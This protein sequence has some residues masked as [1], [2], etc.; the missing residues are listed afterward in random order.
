MSASPFDPFNATLT[1]A[2]AQPDALAITRW[3]AAQ[4]LSLGRETF[5]GDPLAG[6]YLCA[7]HGLVMPEWLADAYARGYEKVLSCRVGTWDEAFGPAHRKNGKHHL[8]TMRLHRQYGLWLERLFAP[9]NPQ[10]LPR[11]PAGYREAARR[12]G[13]TEKQVRTLLPKRRSNVRGHK[14]YSADS[15]PPISAHDPF[16]LARG[17]EPKN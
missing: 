2:M 10:K 11:T 8:S 15:A 13:I 5:E 4:R 14:P 3:G 17:Q 12:L 16:S 1:E 7:E 6:V 9:R